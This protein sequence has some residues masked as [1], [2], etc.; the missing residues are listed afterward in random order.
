MQQP[1]ISQTIDERFFYTDILY[2]CCILCSWGGII[3][4]TSIKI[5]FKNGSFCICASIVW[6]NIRV[7][8]VAGYLFMP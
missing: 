7:H 4:K 5:G 6:S 3:K 2:V 1:N 8:K